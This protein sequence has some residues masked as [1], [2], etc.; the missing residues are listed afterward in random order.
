MS[1]TEVVPADVQMLFRDGRRAF[2][3]SQRRQEAEKKAELEA[4]RLAPPTWK[5]AV[6]AVDAAAAIRAVVK[7]P[8]SVKASG[9][10]RND[11]K[12]WHVNFRPDEKGA[13]IEALVQK[14]RT[15][16]LNRFAELP[17]SMTEFERITAGPVHVRVVAQYEPSRDEYWCRLEILAAR[18]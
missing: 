17:D 14:V 5:L 7:N 10:Y 16:K 12:L 8:R 13:A 15:E 11:L 3:E 18:A 6:I 2:E 4:R 1:V 9:R